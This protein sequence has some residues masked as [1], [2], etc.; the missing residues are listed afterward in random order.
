MSWRIDDAHGTEVCCGLVSEEEARAVA[1]LVAERTGRTVYYME[2]REGA[3]AH[4]VKPEPR[5]WPRGEVPI[6]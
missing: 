1:A 3:T 2:D 4:E 6:Q 5:C